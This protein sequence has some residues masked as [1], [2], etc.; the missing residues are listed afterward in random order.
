MHLLCD[1]V[2][3]A[4]FS[5]GLSLIFWQSVYSQGISAVSLNAINATGEAEILIRRRSGNEQ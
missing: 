2:R 1:V 3:H 4:R 5:P